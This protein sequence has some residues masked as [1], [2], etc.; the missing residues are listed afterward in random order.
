MSKL[1]KNK[2]SVFEIVQGV[3]GNRTHTCTNTKGREPNNNYSEVIKILNPG[4]S[5]NQR[6]ILPDTGDIGGGDPS[7]IWKVNL[8]EFT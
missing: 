3:G 5:I 7:T 8:M 6:K 1:Y 2:T 4:E